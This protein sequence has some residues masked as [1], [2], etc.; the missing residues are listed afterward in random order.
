M[1]APEPARTGDSKP[2]SAIKKFL[3]WAG[4]ITAVL[5]F[6]AAVAQAA[7][8]VL[9]RV[10]SDRK[11]NALLASESVQV[12]GGDYAS[13]WQTL[14]QAGGIRGDSGKVRSA[15]EK[16]AMEWLDS[17]NPDSEQRYSDIVQKIEPVLTRGATAA[18][19][20]AY[21]A[22]LLAHVGW[23][24]FLETT[25]GKD[26]L[27]PAAI[28]TQAVKE[29]AANPYAQ[30]MWGYW[31]LWMHGALSDAKPHFDAALSSGRER[32]FVRERQL[33]VLLDGNGRA[34]REEILRVLNQARKENLGP[35]KPYLGEI[36]DVYKKMMNDQGPGPEFFETLPPA[37][38]LATFQWLFGA[39]T[40]SYY[41]YAETRYFMALLEEANGD[42]AASLR[43]YQEMV[44][45]S[46]YESPLTKF[47]RVALE[48]LQKQ[49]P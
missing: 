47:S 44:T 42:K 13:A 19:S 26:G 41:E 39:M 20:P 29:D 37:E 43:D 11:I 14:E 1:P 28:Y 16:L 24:Y 7:R 49:Q 45:H 34:N 48:R 9:D 15:Q 40:A 38:H 23:C 21:R 10:E 27:D 3:K 18:R 46:S 17:L 32:R 6:I 5:S 30:A 25:E 2:D 22:D 4:Y 31:I 35:P 36:L 33:M 8:V 12:E